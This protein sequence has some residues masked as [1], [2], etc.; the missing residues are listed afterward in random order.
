VYA[1]NG[2][3]VAIAV[4]IVVVAFCNAVSDGIIVVGVVVVRIVVASA[5]NVVIRNVV[6][7]VVVFVIV[8]GVV[9]IAVIRI[10]FVVVDSIRRRKHAPGVAVHRPQSPR[11]ADANGRRRRP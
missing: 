9:R 3:A 4:N 8:V 11:H 1:R 6:I 5:F 2:D 10:A 7:I